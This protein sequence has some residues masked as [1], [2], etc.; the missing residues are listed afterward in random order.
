MKPSTLL[1]EG[2]VRAVANRRPRGV[3]L[4][5]SPKSRR[6]N[7]QEL[8]CEDGE[9]MANRGK[10]DSELAWYILGQKACLG[11]NEQAEGLGS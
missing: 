2:G 9:S 11:Y 10:G 4:I 6:R 3:K 8:T 5:C 7:G 1:H